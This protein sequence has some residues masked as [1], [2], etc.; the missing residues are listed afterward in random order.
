MAQR[1]KHEGE[2]HWLQEAQSAQIKVAPVKELPVN[3]AI[4]EES[5]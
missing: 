1:T 3:T 2:E 5:E 4:F